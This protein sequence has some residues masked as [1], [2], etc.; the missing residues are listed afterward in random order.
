MIYHNF[1][2]TIN[3]IIKKLK[4]IF[5]TY[6]KFVKLNIEFYNSN[7]DMSVKDKKKFFEIFYVYFK[8]LIPARSFLIYV[9]SLLIYVRNP[10]FC[11]SLPTYDP[12]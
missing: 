5:E 8:L 1:Y 2:F 11:I 7:F 4:D 9:H 10:L 3:E 6:N 12:F